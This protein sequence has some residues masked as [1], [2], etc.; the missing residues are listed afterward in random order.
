MCGWG[1]LYWTVWYRTHLSLLKVLQYITA[2]EDWISSIAVLWLP[3]SPLPFPPFS[4]FGCWDM[5]NVVITKLII[6]TCSVPGGVPSI[7]QALSQLF[8]TKILTGRHCHYP[9][10]P[11]EKPELPRSEVTCSK[12]QSW[13]PVCS[14]LFIDLCRGLAPLT[15]AQ[16]PFLGL[17]RSLSRSLSPFPFQIAMQWQCLSWKRFQN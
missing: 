6:Y 9:S 16:I 5:D 3:S 1:L 7:Y 2:L 14:I 11:D 10:F 13:G 15:E 12:L 4:R 8:L 17:S